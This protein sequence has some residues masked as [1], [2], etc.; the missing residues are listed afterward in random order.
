MSEEEGAKAE[1]VC[2]VEN[3]VFVAVGKNVKEGKSTLYWAVK[4]FSRKRICILHVHQPTQLLSASKFLSYS[5]FFSWTIYNPL[6]IAIKICSFVIGIWL[7]IAIWIDLGFGGFMSRGF[8]VIWV[9]EILL[10]E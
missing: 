7:K 5:F 10:K 3:T 6:T 1:G 8:W 2:D 4:S 9:S